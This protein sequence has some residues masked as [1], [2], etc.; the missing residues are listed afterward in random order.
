[1]CD[2]SSFKSAP[3]SAS[4]LFARRFAWREIERVDVSELITVVQVQGGAAVHTEI[5]AVMASNLPTVSGESLW[6]N[7]TL[8]CI[9]SSFVRVMPRCSMCFLACV[10]CGIS[11]NRLCC[12]M[13]TYVLFTLSLTAIHLHKHL[14][15]IS[16]A[17]LL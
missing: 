6:C 5:E 15:V 7:A 10:H 9:F 16:D 2:Y 8:H 12:G 14:R 11:R 1:M 3:V 13:R 17:L 4:T